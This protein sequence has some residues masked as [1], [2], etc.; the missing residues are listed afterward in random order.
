RAA[1][2][3]LAFL[4]HIQRDYAW[5]FPALENLLDRRADDA[6][7]AFSAGQSRLNSAILDRLSKGFRQVLAR[8]EDA[9]VIACGVRKVASL[10][11]SVPQ[12]LNFA[13]PKH[14][15]QL[16]DACTLVALLNGGVLHPIWPEKQVQDLKARTETLRNVLNQSTFWRYLHHCRSDHRY[17]FLRQAEYAPLFALMPTAPGGATTEMAMV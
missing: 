10:R 9:D 15:D 11:A 17:G 5:W 2:L 16:E 6:A 3:D 7:T 4:E 12:D 1:A 14:L 13:E 8:Y